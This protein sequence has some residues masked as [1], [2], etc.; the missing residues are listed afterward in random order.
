MRETELDP[1]RLIQAY[2]AGVWRYLRVLGCEASLADDLT[3][4][5]FLAILNRP[6]EDVSPTATSAYLRKTALHL[7]I[8]HHRRTGRMRTEADIENLDQ[9]WTAWAGGDGGDA[10]IEHLRDCLNELTERARR[11]LEMRFRDDRSRSEIAQELEITEHGAKNLMQ[12][13]KQQLRE[14]VE[15]KLQ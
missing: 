11:A 13:A 9:S 15:H 8:S 5:T 12:R 3:Q 6:F 2:Q 1:V 10:A 7:Y 14:C 4:E